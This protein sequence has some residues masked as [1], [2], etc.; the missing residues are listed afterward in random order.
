MNEILQDALI[1]I[2]GALGSLLLAYIILYINKAKAKLSLEI[3]KIDDEKQRGLVTSAIN[4]VNDLVINSVAMANQTIVAELKLAIENGTTDRSELLALGQ[5]VAN[6]IYVQLTP[7][8]KETLETEIVDIEA[9]IL[10]VVENQVAALKPTVITTI[11]P[12]AT[13]TVT[14]VIEGKDPVVVNVTT[15]EV[16]TDISQESDEG[17]ETVSTDTSINPTIELGV[18]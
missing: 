5:K 13:E 17:I 8:I 15:P 11:N 4:R 18:L 10:T 9:Y 14:T 16:I 12:T 1:K 6:D 2:G 3:S 7:S